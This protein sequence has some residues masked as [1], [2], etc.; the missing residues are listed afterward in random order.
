MTCNKRKK[1]ESYNWTNNMKIYKIRQS[2]KSFTSPIDKN[3]KKTVF[4]YA[5][6][7]RK[8]EHIIYV[9]QIQNTEFIK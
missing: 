3:W 1:L 5:V 2:I 9:S 6:I 4:L 8:L 7:H